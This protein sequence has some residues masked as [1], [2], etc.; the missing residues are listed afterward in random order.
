MLH[1]GDADRSPATKRPC[2][3]TLA[4]RSN[5]GAAAPN[6][7]VPVPVPMPMPCGLLQACEISSG[8]SHKSA[9][10]RKRRPNPIAQALRAAQ[11]LPSLRLALGSIGMSSMCVHL[12]R[13][14]SSA[15]CRAVHAL[16]KAT[17][18]HA[19]REQ[20]VR[21][22]LGSTE[23]GA[24]AT[25]A[26]VGNGGGGSGKASRAGRSKKKRQ[27]Q[28]QQEQQ[29]QQLLAAA[30]VKLH[31][32]KGAAELVYVAVSPQ[33]RCLGLA[34]CLV[35]MAAKLTQELRCATLVVSAATHAV[36]YWRRDGL[37]TVDAG[38][39]GGDGDGGGSEPSFDRCDAQ[40]I[41]KLHGLESAV[42]DA[43]LLWHEVQREGE[44]MH[45]A[46]LAATVAKWQRANSASACLTPRSVGRLRQGGGVLGCLPR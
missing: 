34:R 15:D 12:G 9:L 40:L 20:D 37:L 35:A 33:H 38:G 30:T 23:R 31:L 43:V 5:T 19:Y 6:N 3:G 28:Q 24:F 42:S 2:R 45:E 21:A 7:A 1:F 41:A 13:G 11:A 18:P 27:Q 36:P 25:L 8:A 16:Y 26:I 4:E 39:G 44:Y 32:D 22:M 14:A 29:Q 46:L 17:F 10:H